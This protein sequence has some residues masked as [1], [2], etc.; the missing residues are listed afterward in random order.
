MGLL[1]IRSGRFSTLGLISDLALVGA[2]AG[3]LVRRGR[4]NPQQAS[5]TELLLA[6][7][8]AFR[9]V[10]RLRLRSRS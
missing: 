8:A 7:G 3:R 1:R 2:T 5:V 10:Q 9:L 6:T 4:G